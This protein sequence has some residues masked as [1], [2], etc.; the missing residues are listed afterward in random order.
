MKSLRLHRPWPSLTAAFLIPLLAFLLACGPGQEPTPTPTA[1][2]KPAA[3]PTATPTAAPLATAT[4]TRPG[5]TATPTPTTVATPTPTT[6]P[7]VRIKRGGTLRKGV[8]G[9]PAGFDPMMHAFA[10]TDPHSNANLYSY[11]LVNRVG[12]QLECDLCTTW[13][14]EDG[15]KTLVFNLVRNASFEDGSPLTSKDVVYSLKKMTGEIDGKISPRCGIIKEYLAKDVA[16]P[17]EASDAYTVKIHLAHPSAAVSLNLAT[18]YC[19]ILKEG[20]TTKNVLTRSN[21]SGPFRIGKW[22]VGASLQL[23]PTP[24]YWKK[25]SNGVV[26]PYLDALEL[27]VVSDAEAQRAAAITGRLDHGGNYAGATPDALK[28]AEQFQKVG[29][30]TFLV[31][32]ADSV[33]GIIMNVSKPPFNNLKLRQAVN[34]AMDRTA[35]RAIVFNDWAYAVLY[36]SANYAGARKE[37]EIWNVVPG[38]GT[39]AKKQAELEQAKQLMKEAG[40]GD[41][42][43]VQ[44][45]CFNALYY[46]L[47]TAEFATTVLQ[48]LGIKA[49]LKCYESTATFFPPMANLEYQ[50]AGYIYGY[51]MPEPDIML[52]SYFITGGNR[53]WSGL[54]DPRIDA[55]Y[56]QEKAEIDPQKR[57]Q[58]VRQAE[59]IILDLAP[60][61]P[62]TIYYGGL[63]VW[64]HVK[65]WDYG[66]GS[67]FNNRFEYVYDARVQ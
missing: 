49:D 1:T 37:E 59:D 6:S 60:W 18:N 38:W 47:S 61:A 63:L 28:T 43:S 11:L 20:T 44:V 42:F 66:I 48:R 23:V 33:G 46:E 29:K 64:N 9:D 34:L 16:Q 56:L 2:P 57:I 31:I 62:A 65:G 53:N 12:S 10:P 35:Q 52:G 22:N 50:I 25:D 55:L 58:L 39:G 40:Y 41:G 4:P 7:A 27:V 19:A 15:G 36:Q 54:S 3:T 24:N 67:Y 51:G 45:Y 14:Q 30:G 8:T 13:K 5:P 32:K 17:F 21:G 26:L